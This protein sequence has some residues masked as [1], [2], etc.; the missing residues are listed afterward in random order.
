MIDRRM[1]DV[2]ILQELYAKGT[3]E[4]YE[5]LPDRDYIA[6]LREEAMAEHKYP[7]GHYPIHVAFFAALGVMFALLVGVI[8]VGTLFGIASPICFR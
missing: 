3:R 2:K 4:L 7:P 8:Y 6:A 5:A 1:Q